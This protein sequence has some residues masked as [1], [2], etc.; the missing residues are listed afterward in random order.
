MN[1]SITN[2]DSKLASGGPSIPAKTAIYR[3]E[4]INN[5]VNEK[6]RSDLV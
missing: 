1:M 5:A 3:M 6:G 2:N 4:I